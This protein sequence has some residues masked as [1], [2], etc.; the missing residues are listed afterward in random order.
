MEPARSSPPLP[1]LLSRV[2]RRTAIALTVV[3]VLV[4]IVLVVLLAGLGNKCTSLLN[5]VEG[6]LGYR[7]H[8]IEYGIS[9]WPPGLECTAV[10][11]D[12]TSFTGVVPWDA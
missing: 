1:S 7:G 4:P 2:R 3:V 10:W 11:P 9:L 5:R 6:D 12:G 8:A